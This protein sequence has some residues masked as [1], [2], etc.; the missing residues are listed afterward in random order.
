MRASLGDVAHYY[1]YVFTTIITLDKSIR[2]DGDKT[3]KR[4]FE[5]LHTFSGAFT[6]SLM[7]TF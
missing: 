6:P 2:L 7:T 4:A 5:E 1:K 3:F